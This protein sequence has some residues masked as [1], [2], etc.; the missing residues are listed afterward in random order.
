MGLHVWYHK[1]PVL[2]RSPPYEAVPQTL[3]GGGSGG[4]TEQRGA[5][6]DQPL[7]PQE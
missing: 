7:S 6:G 3:L 1:H 2:G 5:N 4:R